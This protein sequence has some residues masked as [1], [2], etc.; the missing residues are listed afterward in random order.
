MRYTIAVLKHKV[1]LHLAHGWFLNE[2][3]L[4]HRTGYS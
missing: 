3:G 2:G 4:G 1:H